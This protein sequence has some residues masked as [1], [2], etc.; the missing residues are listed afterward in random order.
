VSRSIPLSRSHDA[1]P[2]TAAASLPARVTGVL[3][4]PRATFAALARTP[5]WVAVMGLT[6]A[7]T[8]LSNAALLE[9]EVGRLAL[10]DQ[11]ERTAVAFGQAVDDTRHATFERASGNGVLYAALIALASGPVLV[12]GVS[13][14]LFALLTRLGGGAVAYR[15][16]LAITAHAG[17]ILA[18]RQVVAAPLDYSRETLASPATLGVLFSTLDEASPLAR[19]FGVIDLFV[20]W[21]VATL[22]IGVSVLS[23]RPAR[24]L[25][26]GFI[27][28][29]LVLAAVLALV[30]AFSGGT[31]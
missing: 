26:L 22:A 3:R 15:Q 1:I 24:H 19:F 30:M 28:A 6:L 25:A 10:M 7:V 18:L 2:S 16:V 13:L 29:Y 23:R 14:L 27:G 12:F 9:T 11:W 31:T 21:W 5:R 20:I 8:F 4:A 17:V